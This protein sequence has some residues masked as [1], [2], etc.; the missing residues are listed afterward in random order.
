MHGKDV[1]GGNV[2]LWQDICD[3]LRPCSTEAIVRSSCHDEDTAEISNAGKFQSVLHVSLASPSVLRHATEDVW[4]SYKS[5]IL[6][7]EILIRPMLSDV[8]YSGVVFTADMETMVDYY[9]VNYQDGSD[10][11]AVTSG[12]TNAIKTFI[13]YKFAPTPIED[14]DMVSLLSACTEIEAFLKNDALDIELGINNKHEL[15]H[16]LMNR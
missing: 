16:S 15:Y 12:A 8:V 2:S 1:F 13:R 4:C 3:R 7:E 9:T 11:E 6:D 5:E 10:T 14:A